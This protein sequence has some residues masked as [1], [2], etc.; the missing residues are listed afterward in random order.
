M[1]AKHTPGPWQVSS[2]S[3]F[4]VHNGGLWV[5]SAMDVREDEGIANMRLT[6]AAPDLLKAAKEVYEWMNNLPIPTTGCTTKMQVLYD[7]IHKA[8]GGAA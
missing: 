4:F 6:A 3:Q 5:A 8:E 7:A 1:S 2:G